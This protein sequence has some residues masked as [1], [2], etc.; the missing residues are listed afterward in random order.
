MALSQRVTRSTNNSKQGNTI[1]ADSSAAAVNTE[2]ATNPAASATDPSRS[3]KAV[4]DTEAPT[5]EAIPVN[6]VNIDNVKPEG[7]QHTV[8]PAKKGKKKNMLSQAAYVPPDFTH[9]SPFHCNS[10]AL[11]EKN[12]TYV[13]SMVNPR[14]DYDHVLD[15]GDASTSGPQEVPA[16]MYQHTFA[17]DK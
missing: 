15:T 3:A 13:S 5:E 12:G 10:G 14:F 11:R 6:A 9:T 2:A 7:P 16:G 17:N 1:S 8:A 4:A